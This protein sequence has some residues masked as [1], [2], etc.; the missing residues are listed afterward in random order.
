MGRVWEVVIA[1]ADLE[2]RRN[3]LG[4][5]TQQGVDCLCASTVSQ[6]QEIL[7]GRKI[8]LVF[9][10]RKFSDGSY[11]DILRHTGGS[12]NLTT[13]VVVMSALMTPFEYE[14]ARRC[15]VFDVISVPCRP[16]DI[17]WMVILA[18]RAELIR[19]QPRG[20]SSSVA[21]KSP[22]AS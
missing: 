11:Q 9:S 22:S 18:K 6:C 7:S 13:K 4:M 3:V 8:G 15:G 16:T 14:Q 19:P 12:G 5:L 21:V 17:E 2:N 20:V 10:D 1:S